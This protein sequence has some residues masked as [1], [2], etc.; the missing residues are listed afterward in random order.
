VHPTSGVVTGTQLVLTFSAAVVC[1]ASC[2]GFSVID[3]THNQAVGLQFNPTANGTANVIFSLSAPVAPG[4]QI[5]VSYQPGNLLDVA[6]SQP[7]AALVNQP[8]TNNTLS[9]EGGGGGGGGCSINCGPP[10]SATP[11]LNSLGLFASG[12]L[13]LIGAQVARRRR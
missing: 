13:T 1:S 2:F 7:I 8:V 11:E 10:P 12:L 6:T 3:L 9:T 5:A 4:D